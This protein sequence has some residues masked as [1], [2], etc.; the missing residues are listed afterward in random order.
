M[1]RIEKLTGLKRGEVQIGSFLKRV[2]LTRRKIGM[3]PAKADVQRQEEFKK[4]LQPRLDEA[5]TEKWA[6]YFVD[7]AR[8]VLVPFLG[9]LWSFCRLFIKAPAGRQRLNVLGALNA[10]SHYRLP[11]ANAFDL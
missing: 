6:V 4:T 10:V 1:G 11:V 3:I 2:G 7:A 8:F 9:Y 5:Q